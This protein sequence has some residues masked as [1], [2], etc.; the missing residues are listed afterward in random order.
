MIALPIISTVVALACAFAVGRDM[1]RKPKP[2]RATW[3]VAFL[4]FAIAAGAEVIGE[5]SGWTPM[6]VRLYYVTGAVLVVGFLAMGQMYLTAPKW[7]ARIGPGIA[8]LMTALSVSAVWGATVDSTRLEADGWRALDRTTGVTL[9]AIGINSL[10]TMILVG[11]LVYSV[12]RFRQLG[13][14]RNRMIGCLLIAGGTLTVAT[15]GTLTRFGADQY[16]YI[17]MS[18]GILMIFTGYLWTKVPEGSS[19]GRS[20]SAQVTTATI[21]VATATSDGR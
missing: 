10:G 5:A 11:G 21:P 16:L 19:L 13:T 15:G 18:V 1:V 17:A 20:R 2:D 12:V 6:L 3:L 7:T 4:L 9:L 8:L 14:M